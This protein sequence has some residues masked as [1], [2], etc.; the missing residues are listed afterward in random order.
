MSI[1]VIEKKVLSSDREHQLAGVVYLPD[2]APKGLFHVVHGMTEHIG[3]YE[4]FMR[5]LAAAGYIT[6]G[7][8]NLGHGKT[9]RNESEL[10]YIAPQDGWKLLVK[11]VEIFDRAMRAEYG[12]ELPLTLMGHSMGSFIVRLSAEISG[13]YDKLIIMGTGGPRRRRRD[14][15]NR[16]DDQ[17]QRR[18]RLLH[19]AR[20]GRFRLLQHPLQKRAGSAL[21]AYQRR[22]RPPRL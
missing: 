21:M 18:P 1:K 11:D 22:I 20:E 14:Q 15:A 4:R 8:D 13:Y 12:E 3:R 5:D 9:A 16:Y 17:I 6:Y 19:P 2:S 7:Y 10:G